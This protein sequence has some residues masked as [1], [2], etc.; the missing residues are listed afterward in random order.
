[1]QLP[2]ITDV[3]DLKGKRVLLRLDFNVP[4]AG[5]KITD[6]FRIKAAL[7][8]INMLRKAGARVIILSHLE[9]KGGDTLRP[10]ADYLLAAKMPIAFVPEYFSP[11]TDATLGKMKDG[12]VVLFENLRMNE[13]E[14][15]NDP[16]FAEKLATMGDLYVNE[17]FPV[18]H[19]AHASVSALPKLFPSSSYF[20]PVFIR[21]VE[22]LSQALKPEHPFLFILGGAKFETKLTL[23]Q[24]FFTL[25]DFIFVGGALANNFYKEIGYE[26]GDSVVSEGD[27]GLA[28]FFVVKKIT[29]PSD[30]VVQKAGDSGERVVKLANMVE[31]GEKIFDIGPEGLKEV[32]KLVEQARCILWNGPLGNYEEGY[33]EGTKKLA[34]IIS[35]SSA[36]TIV[37]GGDTVAAIESLGLMDKFTF[38]STGGGAM[39]DFLANETLPGISAVVGGK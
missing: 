39:L 18:S 26:I 22:N 36:K 9:G 1:M 32:A 29:V 25:S 35:K 38:V 6:D 23:L 15:K 30:A 27:F 11:V 17:A 28:G 5:G 10:V 20:G 34:E 21:E 16:E 4:I 24:K 19:R 7:P 3:K 37:G 13:G 33:S 2:N 12:D 31:K 8:T 14:K